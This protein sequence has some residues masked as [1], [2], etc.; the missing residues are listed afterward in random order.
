MTPELKKLFEAKH[1]AYHQYQAMQQMNV[2]G[3]PP[4]ELISMDIAMET[5]KQ[6]W[7][8]ATTEYNA[9]LEKHVKDSR[10]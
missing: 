6:D 7:L 9:A 4:D 3:K 2:C 1:L 5:A 10:K 8:S